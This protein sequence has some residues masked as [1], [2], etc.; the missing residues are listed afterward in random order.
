VLQ[1]SAKTGQGVEDAFTRLAEAV[2]SGQ[3]AEL[4]TGGR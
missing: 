3:I 1:A 4:A 2:L